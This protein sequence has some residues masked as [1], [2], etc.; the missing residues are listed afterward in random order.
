MSV[1]RARRWRCAAAAAAVSVLLCGC[2]SLLERQY[3][4]VEP[5]SRRF[6][7]SGDSGVLRAEE[8]PEIVNA[9][10]TL[11]SAH[12]GEGVVR[13]YMPQKTVVEAEA[14]LESACLEVQTETPLGAYMVEYLRYTVTE[15]TAYWEAELTIDYRRTAEQYEAMVNVTSSAAVADLVRAAAEEG[16]SDLAL[17]ISYLTDTEEELMAQLAA[18]EEEMTG[19]SGAWTVT[20]YPRGSENCIAEFVF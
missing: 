15:E 3:S 10:L 11:V 2:S 6:W 16:R 13:V 14:L 1:A 7:E 20:L 19:Q 8:Y 5:H 17:R 18:L 12:S 9:I 4:V